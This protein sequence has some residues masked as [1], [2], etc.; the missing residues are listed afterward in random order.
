MAYIVLDVETAGPF[1][2]SLVYDL[3]L[4]LCWSDGTII[5]SYSWVIQD[6]FFDMP[7][8]MKSAYYEYK[9][10]MYNREI[11]NGNHEVLT[12]AEA[13][14]QF[15]EIC[16]EYRVRDVWAY[17]AQFDERAL[18]Y[19]VNTLSRGF[20]AKFLPD[21]VRMKCIMG[22]FLSTL[23][24]TDRYAGSAARTEKGNIKVSAEEAFRYISQDCEFMEEH[25]GLA[26]A[27]IENE[28]L[29]ACRKCHRK[30]DTKPKQ[31]TAFPAWREL[32]KR[33]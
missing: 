25:T 10:P 6:V 11:A 16:R 3:G 24:A 31:V 15:H 5:K 30:M 7:H 32:Q 21:T 18:N 33:K 1:G 23:G 27:V 19:T 2:K 29:R 14:Y 9:I 26:D 8:K 20:V 17:N 4:V 12:M 13:Y 28:I 22:A